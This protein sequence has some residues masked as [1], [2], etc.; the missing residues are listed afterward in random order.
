M[1]LH[2][3]TLPAH[4]AEWSL[5]VPTR[6]C[7]GADGRTH[8]IVGRSRAMP[9][10]RCRRSLPSPGYEHGQ[11]SRSPISGQRL[12]ETPLRAEALPHVL[13][14]Y[15][16]RLGSGTGAAF[17]A[18]ACSR[19]TPAT[20]PA[21]VSPPSGPAPAPCLRC[22]R[23]SRLDRRPE[24]GGRASSTRSTGRG[25]ASMRRWRTGRQLRPAGRCRR[26]ARGTTMW[27]SWYDYFTRVTRPTSPR[28]TW[29]LSSS[30]TC[31][32]R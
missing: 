24:R 3:R 27:C 14:D 31:P 12:A 15:R 26:A 32:S 2:Y 13:M 23:G 18:R 10:R 11:Q 25:A 5:G 22:D 19:W 30:W 6:T 16:P 29:P 8:G 20:G 4:C 21:S 1:N 7:E 17:G 28:R 9:S